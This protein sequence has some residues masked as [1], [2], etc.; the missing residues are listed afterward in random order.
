VLRIVL[1]A[2]TAQLGDRSFVE[3]MCRVARSGRNVTLYEDEYRCPLPAGVI[4]RTIWEQVDHGQPGLYHVG[5]QERLSRWDIGEVLL[6]WYPE[7]KGRL[8][9][10]S[11][12]DHAGA[13]RP[14]DLSLTCDKIR[15][16][17]SFPIPGFREWLAERSTRGADL[18]D[19]E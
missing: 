13:P 11:A 9:R 18:W 8:A 10:G 7:L 17:L 12:S 14:T 2:G 6:P 3:D 5:G 1:T 4:A 15:S 16:I 19:Y